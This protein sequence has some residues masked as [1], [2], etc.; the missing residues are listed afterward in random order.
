MQE[1]MDKLLIA[2]IDHHVG[3]ELA[4]VIAQIALDGYTVA[5]NKVDLSKSVRVVIYKYDDMGTKEQLSYLVE[6]QLLLEG[7]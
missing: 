2:L 3:G 4:K 6:S 1:L 5:F 7:S